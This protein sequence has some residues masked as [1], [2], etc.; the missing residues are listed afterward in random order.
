MARYNII[1]AMWG[2]EWKAIGE[3]GNSACCLVGGIW[4]IVFFYIFQTL[5]GNRY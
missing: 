2:G 3:G 5:Y 1:T 4:G